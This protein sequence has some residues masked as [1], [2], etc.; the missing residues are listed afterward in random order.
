MLPLDGRTCLLLKTFALRLRWFN[1][2]GPCFLTFETSA[3]AVTESNHQ[4]WLVFSPRTPE[5]FTWSSRISRGQSFIHLTLLQVSTNFYHSVISALWSKWRTIAFE[6][7]YGMTGQRKSDQQFTTDIA[8]PA[9]EREAK[10]CSKNC[11]IRAASRPGTFPVV[12][13]A[14]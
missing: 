4:N 13:M 9:A 3:W 10:S 8:M 11:R 14:G 12:L 6:C 1:T 7:F 5:N 2:G